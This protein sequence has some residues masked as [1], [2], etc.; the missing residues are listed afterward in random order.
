MKTAYTSFS[1]VMSVDLSII[2][3][4]DSLLQRL[5]LFT[6]D[7]SISDLL[8]VFFFLWDVTYV[9]DMCTCGAMMRPNTGIDLLMRLTYFTTRCRSWPTVLGPQF[10]IAFSFG[11]QY[12]SVQNKIQ[13]MLFE[14]N[15]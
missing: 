7:C 2:R 14:I 15:A 4:I 5:A 9:E 3:V 11:N 10:Y 6:D 13:S 8:G 1:G 12:K